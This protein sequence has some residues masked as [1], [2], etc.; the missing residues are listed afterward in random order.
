MGCP[1]PKIVKNGEG[2]AL[3]KKPELL[4]DV[5]AAM[6]KAAGKP[7]TAKIRMGF[8]QV[9]NLAVETARALEAAGAA[10]VTVHG[11]TREQYYDGKADWQVIADVKKSVRIPVIGNGDVN[12]GE[13]AVAMMEQ[14]GCDGVMIARGALGNP[15]IFRDAQA[16]WKGEDKP[17]AP[18]KGERIL[19]LIRHLDMVAE[20]KGE[21]IA[22]REMRKHVGWYVRGMHGASAIKREIN[23]IDDIG[24]MRETIRSIIK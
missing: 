14:T 19:M 6:V 10:A 13:D 17:P 7:V 22:V 15:W 24:I 16:L 5:V 11:R 12:T 23:Q 8:A 21:R 4:F 3:L 9:E 20:D 1:V 18:S 2:S